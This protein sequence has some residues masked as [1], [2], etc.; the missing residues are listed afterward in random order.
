MN[1]LFIVPAAKPRGNMLR[2]ATE[3][4]VM[5]TDESALRSMLGGGRGCG[6]DNADFLFSACRGNI[7]LV[8][9]DAEADFDEF[10]LKARSRI[11]R[12]VLVARLYSGADICDSETYMLCNDSA[13]LCACI[14]SFV[15]ATACGASGI[16]GSSDKV[17]REFVSFYQTFDIKSC[18]RKLHE[19]IRLFENS[20]SAPIRGAS[21]SLLLT[22][23]EML[24][25]PEAGEDARYSV[26][27]NA[28]AFISSKDEEFRE[29][30]KAVKS[31]YKRRP[32]RFHSV[33]AKDASRSSASLL[34]HIVSRVLLKCI[35]AEKTSEITG[36]APAK[37][38]FGSAG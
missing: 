14:A 4:S 35:E 23:L 26:A 21:A 3:T 27:W 28:A 30:Y 37:A 19:A 38:G 24:F 6:C 22:A 11:R 29:N 13:P 2:L 32:K 18:P 33:R 17:L 16:F 12:F 25:A 20:F 10:K 9:E 36:D 31:F 8:I 7:A 34:L 15:P 1:S 5:R